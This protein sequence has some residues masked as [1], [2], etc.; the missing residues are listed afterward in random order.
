MANAKQRGNIA[1][2]LA[3]TQPRRPQQRADAGLV[4]L[5]LPISAFMRSLAESA[6]LVS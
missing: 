5:S 1:Q 4:S 6:F 2:I 3:A